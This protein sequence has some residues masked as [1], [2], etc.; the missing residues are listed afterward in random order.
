MGQILS[1]VRDFNS[2]ATARRLEKANILIEEH[3]EEFHNEHALCCEG[4]HIASGGAAPAVCPEAHDYCPNCKVSGHGPAS[5]ASFDS[6]KS[7]T[8]WER[9]K[10]RVQFKKEADEAHA[11]KEQELGADVSAA[12]TELRGLDIEDPMQQ[13]QA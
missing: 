2:G 12:L 5:Q 4:A 7:Q 1:V 6:Q 11:T 8:A 13:D 3:S 9:K 10:L